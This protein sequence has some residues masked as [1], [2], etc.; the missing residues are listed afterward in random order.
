MLAIPYEDI[1][2][3]ISITFLFFY[4]FIYFILIIFYVFMRIKYFYFHKF[5]LK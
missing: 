1:E 3:F 2:C 5:L 4:K